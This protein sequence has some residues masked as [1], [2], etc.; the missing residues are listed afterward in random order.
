M[1]RGLGILILITFGV[2]GIAILG[3]EWVPAL[4]MD[5]AMA[6]LG[7][8]IGLGVAVFQGLKLKKQN[9]T[10]QSPVEVEIEE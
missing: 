9:Q 2:S 1:D 8:F 3:L 5:K 10:Q 4:H 7:G 6:T